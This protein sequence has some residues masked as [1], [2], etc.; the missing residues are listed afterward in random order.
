MGLRG[1]RVCV[2]TIPVGQLHLF[3]WEAREVR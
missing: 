2:Y 1:G 3:L